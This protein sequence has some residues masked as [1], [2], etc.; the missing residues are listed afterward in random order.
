MS[1]TPTLSPIPQSLASQPL[2]DA[3][4]LQPKFASLPCPRLLPALASGLLLWL[5]YFPADCG[6][7]GW[8]ALVPLLTLVRSRA[9]AR[10]VYFS[11]WLG[12]LVFFVAAIQWMRVA[13]P[14][15]VY[16]WL[17]LSLHCSLFVVVGIF[18]IR[19]LDRHTPLPLVVTVPAVWTA[20]EYSRAHLLGGFPWYFLGHTQHD[21]LAVIQ[22]SDLAGAY[23][24]TFLVAAVNALVFEW[25]YR[26]RAVRRFLALPEEP[27][28]LGLAGLGLCSG[29]VVLA[30]AADLGYG[31]WRLGQENFPA[32]P[33]L[34]LLQGNLDQRLRNDPSTAA[35]QSVQYHFDTLAAVAC[36][37]PVP[38]DLVVWPETSFSVPASA[39][40]PDVTAEAVPAEWQ[41]RVT[42]FR[43]FVHSRMKWWPANSLLGLNATVLQAGGQ[44]DRYNSA[45]YVGADGVPGPRYD[46]MHR[47]PF[48]E[49]VPFREELPW[50]NRFAPYDFEYSIRSGEHWTR[51][52]LAG[53]HFGVVI[54]YE[55]TD[56]YLARQ[57]VAE[58]NC[59]QTREPK[60]D[61]LVNISNDGW[62]DG[63]SEHEQHLAICRF[64][65]IEARRAVVRAVNMGVSA[66]IDGNGQVHAPRLVREGTVA[67]AELKAWEVS[68]KEE[69]LP[70][71]RWAEFKKVAGVLT[72]VV[73]LDD[74]SSL[75]AEL[76][77]WLPAACW[78]LVGLGLAWG[79]TARLL[80]AR[81][82]TAAG[83]APAAGA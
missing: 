24:V 41:D 71:G 43:Q 54:C 8:V 58:A 4:P 37:Q 48:G 46:K 6:W 27:P 31:A 79:V 55:D 14:R 72:A 38:P 63:S 7:L 11:A 40:A 49:Y 56:P 73:P 60:V 18:L 28:R 74:R 2:P 15:M 59:R 21:F 12:G 22:V 13:D 67:G 52:P 65:A 45:L 20:L 64:R 83:T 53:R 3:A 42:A 69:A 23:G 66:L 25:L 16:T 26:S 19:Q 39:V 30:G 76:G 57:Y 75:Y 80:R 10:N 62:F 70:V 36:R 44:E 51:F 47:V 33:R 32:G 61:F 82:V 5:C 81:A 9:R 34:A 35:Q 77:D 50:M 68:A 78:G 1:Q 29:L 17:A